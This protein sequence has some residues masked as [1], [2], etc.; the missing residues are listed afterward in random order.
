MAVPTGI[1]VEQS[2]GE[3]DAEIRMEDIRQSPAARLKLEHFHAVIKRNLMDKKLNY[4]AEHRKEILEGLRHMKRRLPAETGT[5]LIKKLG[6]LAEKNL[7]CTYKNE[8]NTFSMTSDDLTLSIQHNNDQAIG[9]RISYFGNEFPIDNEITRRIN[10]NQWEDLRIVLHSM[11]RTVPSTASKDMK[12]KLC[13]YRL[14][15]ERSLMSKWNRPETATISQ[16]NESSVG[17][18]AAGTSVR[19]M[20]IFIYG[21]PGLEF[22]MKNKGIGT[23]DPENGEVGYAEIV[24]V[25]GEKEMGEKV[26]SCDGST[27]S[28]PGVVK[29][30]LST[31]WILTA[32]TLERLGSV[33]ARPASI[34]QKTNMIRLIGNCQMKDGDIELVGNELNRDIRYLVKGE[35]S[36]RDVIIDAL[37]VEDGRRLEE[38][39]LI[40][41]QQAVFNSSWESVVASCCIKPASSSHSVL[42]ELN[43]GGCN[44]EIVFN[45]NGSMFHLRL[46][47]STTRLWTVNILSNHNGKLNDLADEIEGAFNGTWCLSKCL[48]HLLNR[49]DISGYE[50]KADSAMDTS[51]PLLDYSL[52][53]ESKVGPAWLR[54]ETPFLPPPT[55][56]E[57]RVVLPKG[58]CPLLSMMREVKPRKPLK[59]AK[60]RPQLSNP[61][62]PPLRVNRLD[63]GLPPLH[64]H[65]TQTPFNH[66]E[67]MMKGVDD[68]NRSNVSSM[69]SMDGG[70]P[71]YGNMSYSAPSMGQ[72]VGVAPGT[73][74]LVRGGMGVTMGGVNTAIPSYGAP[75]QE[76]M[77]QQ[78]IRQQSNVSLTNSGVFDF[79]DESRGSSPSSVNEFSPGSG[80]GSQ[81]SGY[82]PPQSP[83]VRGATASKPRRSRGRKAGNVGDRTPGSSIDSP[84]PSGFSPDTKRPKSGPGSRGGR[85]SRGKRGISMDQSMSPFQRSVSEMSNSMSS[86]L[87]PSVTPL[88]SQQSFDEATSD[89]ECDPPPFSRSLST[90]H[91]PT[92]STVVAP[93]R[94][95][96]TPSSSSFTISSSPLATPVSQPLAS[97]S[98][99]SVVPSPLVPL[100]TSTP[101]LSSV[102]SA[103][104]VLPPSLTSTP[105][106]SL[107]SSIPSSVPSSSPSIPSSLSSSLP[108]SSSSPHPSSTT[109]SLI[110]RKSSLELI[111]GQLSATQS[112]KKAALSG[113][114]NDLFDT[115]LEDSSPHS[116]H[117]TAPVLFAE[118]K[119]ESPK[120]EG[121]EEKIVLKLKKSAKEPK[122]K[123]KNPEKEKE[124]EKKKEDK[125]VKSGEERDRKRKAD[126]SSK[127]KKDKEAKKAKIVDPPLIGASE[128][129]VTKMG[130]LKGFKIPKTKGP[131]DVS[132]ASSSSSSS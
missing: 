111:V 45:G 14:N 80:Y 53:Y 91:P 117:L 90:V 22:D 63:A 59:V 105:P 55:K 109:P 38:V 18:P 88:H 75:Q 37:L 128:S 51:L 2:I 13:R 4:E 101:T 129:C 64:P 79:Q 41:H 36:E 50:W 60:P 49:L 126:S 98:I 122:K 72:R 31:R 123:E 77:R 113:G 100:P 95:S 97:S 67:N 108:P 92:A 120:K 112:K 81:F 20:R 124:K 85:G 16:L 73:S 28:F 33:G 32:H 107:P 8:K 71:I 104:S 5:S 52:Q 24:I 57:Y 7:D 1:P 114:T 119:T 96:S 17:W 47:P 30:E 76:M 26:F 106:I 34:L 35:G 83:L 99:I 78:M 127:E 23:I 87:A 65:S 61:T 102:L 68:G 89:E 103:P 121:T 86:P 84:S 43:T 82:A 10:E 11:L 70:S 19:P 54:K 66:I 46:N 94:L 131:G 29:L 130:M 27:F 125:S 69:G 62:V 74:P 21:E 56:H 3:I 9:A 132:M 110:K 6:N 40:L 39:L 58:R 93:S 12:Q 118:T 42:F 15:L 25:E 116:S 48:A 44:W 115:G